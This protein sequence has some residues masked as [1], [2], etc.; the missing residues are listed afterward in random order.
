MNSKT[1]FPNRALFYA[2]VKPFGT[3]VGLSEA[4]GIPTRTLFSFA[5]AEGGS[6]GLRLALMIIASHPQRAED[7]CKFALEWQP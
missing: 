1:K 2:A 5:N 6:A 4:T 7:I 3:V